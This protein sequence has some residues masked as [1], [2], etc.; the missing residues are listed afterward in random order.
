MKQII[1]STIS[2]KD[3]CIKKIIRELAPD[4][5]SDE[6]IIAS[7]RAGVIEKSQTQLVQELLAV[8]DLVSEYGFALLKGINFAKLDEK[9]RK[10]LLLGISNLLGKPTYT[11]QVQKSVIR[12]IAPR[13]NSENKRATISEIS[14]EAEFHTDSQYLPLPEKFFILACQTPAVWGGDSLLLDGKKLI[15]DLREDSEQFYEDL[16][17]E[18][19]TFLVPTSFTKTGDNRSL[20]LLR[21]PIVSEEIPIR[22]REDTIRN[23]QQLV[24]TLFTDKHEKI[25]QQ[26]KQKI[27]E[28]E[29][30]QLR[31]EKNDILVVDNHR[32][33]HGRTDFSDAQRL[34]YRIRMN[35][36]SNAQSSQKI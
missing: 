9:N 16:Q 35:P 22:Y 18:Q 17:N 21:A 1:T 10:N 12:D 28:S 30:L 15:N 3:L 8:Q 31:L 24:P 6:K 11:D 34:L 2:E 13:K 23:A 26:L 36:K 32:F 7:Q 27:Q 20:E 19:F 25:L 5:P 4:S 33:L 29:K 14:G